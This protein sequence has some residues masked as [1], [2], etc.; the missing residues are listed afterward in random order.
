M[1]EV[2]E[3]LLSKTV[4]GGT[5]CIVW[6]GTRSI[7]GYGRIT[8]AGQVRYAHRV[9]FETFSGQC[10]D[11]HV[12]MHACDNPPCVNPNHL[13]LG[14]QSDNLRDCYEKGR[15]RP[16]WGARTHCINGHELT[17]ENL[18]FRRGGRVCR[19]CSRERTAKYRASH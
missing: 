1:M 3:R 4:A 14:T 7:D 8:V 11:G 18:G 12:V 10:A 15:A 6:T 5:E 9:S 17:G 16:G 19:A 13:R 2:I